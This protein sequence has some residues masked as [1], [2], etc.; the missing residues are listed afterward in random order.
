MTEDTQPCT[1]ERE[2]TEMLVNFIANQHSRSD[3]RK[4]EVYCCLDC[5]KLVNFY[6][7]ETAMTPTEIMQM[8]VDIREHLN[9]E[10]EEI[11][12][13]ATALSHKFEDILI[14]SMPKVK[15]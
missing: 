3:E 15:K 14:D 5:G 2:T 7:A 11:M 13:Q 1:H 12:A 10:V 9:D 4:Y 8:F 6:N